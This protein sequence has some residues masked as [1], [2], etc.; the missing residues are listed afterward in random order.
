[1]PFDQPLYPVNLSLAGRRCL[2]VGGGPVALQKARELVVCGAAVEV[3]APEILDEIAAL[4]GVICHKRPYVDG[5]VAGLAQ[6]QPRESVRRP[7]SVAKGQSGEDAQRGHSAKSTHVA[8][9][10]REAQDVRR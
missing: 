6:E 4:D 9:R 3:V 5:E 8:R 2:V 10:A 1:M 7:Q